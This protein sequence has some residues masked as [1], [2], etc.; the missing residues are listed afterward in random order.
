[1][2]GWDQTIWLI[3]LGRH[4]FRTDQNHCVEELERLD[5]ALDDP[6]PDGGLWTGRL[7]AQCICSAVWF[8]RDA[9]WNTCGAWGSL[10]KCRVRAMPGA[11]SPPRSG[12]RPIS[13][14]A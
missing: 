2:I 14:P 6:P 11:T 8:H 7:V 5:H 4:R 13:A 9:A 12:S 1:M 3:F 10:A